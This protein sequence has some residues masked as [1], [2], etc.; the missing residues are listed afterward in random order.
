MKRTLAAL[1]ILAV[2]AVFRA[3]EKPPAKPQ[4]KPPA[5]AP[6]AMS[7][8]IENV[9]VSVTSIDVIVTDS[10]GNRVPGL[11][12]EDFQVLQ[13]GVPQNI[14]NFYAV[15]GGKVLLEDGQTV[16]IEEPKA[17]AV[18][19]QE[20]KARY[21]IYIDNL[22]IQP[23]NR[24]RMFKRLKEFVQ[25]TVG[26][27]A[28]AM[29]VVFNR[30]LKIRKK[31][32]D[33]PSE[34][35][36]VL[37]EIEGETGGASSQVGDRKDTLQ[38]INDA[39]SPDQ[40]ESIAR[41]YAEAY[42]N[43]LEFSVDGIRDTVNGLAGMPGRKVLVYVSEGL[44][45]TVGLEMYDVIQQKFQ[46]NA[47]SL[48]Q[49]EFDMNSRYASIVQAANAQ[50]VTIWALDASG[51]QV[52]D[53][54]TAEN[55]TMDVRPSS[56]IMRTNMQ[57]PLQLMAEQTGGMAA[58]NTNDWKSSLDDLASDFSNF[59]SIGYRST[60]ATVDKPH[61]IEVIVKRKGMHARTRRGLVEKSLETRTAETVV[62]NL[63]YPRIDNPL[64]ISVAMGQAK[65]YD[66]ENYLMP[67]RISIPMSKLGLV[68]SGDRYEG[69]FS[70]Y[71]VV[72]DASDKQSDLAVQ[73]QK[74]EV[75]VADFQKAQG[76]DYYYD[77]SL[78]CVPGGQKLSVALRDGVT[79][80]TSFVQKSF[81]VSVLPPEKK[82]ASNSPS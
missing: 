43:D 11:T 81:F 50:G 79:N 27:Q 3:Q 69:N 44:P 34:I 28:E 23:L 32:T 46:E 59:Y 48:S 29:V 35:L 36:Q 47:N 24:N 19:P 25:Q 49:F 9:E 33:D 70:V 15:T 65:P 17:A 12:K 38:R 16:S 76:K 74:V 18:V 54:I 77:V 30:S 14:T 75:P 4:E 56:F 60:K 8:V 61:S 22:N 21:V 62:A 26:K 64:N 66:R 58:I 63:H 45:A 20:L 2:A 13:D 7:P 82:T 39:T 78:I 31:M 73:R 41:Q 71:F 80:V 72:L 52:D 53:M 42:R 68:P 40:A 55:K 51:L 37:E 67:V 6:Q 57:A 10:K 5:P 1:V